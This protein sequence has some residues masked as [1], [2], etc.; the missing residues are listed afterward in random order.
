MNKYYVEFPYSCTTFG[1]VKGY[2]YAVSKEI[3]EE[4]AGDIDN[5]EDA[6][7]ID[8]DTDNTEHY[9][10]QIELQLRQENILDNDIPDYLRVP[11]E[12]VPDYFL[13]D[14]NLI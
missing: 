3:A 7:Y 8:T 6:E 1:R 9:Y 11:Q 5:I 10:D 4:R 12:S 2:V 14:I 13:S